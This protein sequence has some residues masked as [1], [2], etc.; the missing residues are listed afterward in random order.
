MTG[1]VASLARH[2]VKGFTPEKLE[3]ASLKAGEHFPGDRLYAV[4]D[5]L[6]GFDSDA[7]AHISKMAFTVLAKL[8]DV[9]AMRTKWNDDDGTLTASHPDLGEITI[10]LDDVGGQA[11]FTTW[12]STVLNGQTQGELKVLTAPDAFRFMDSRTGFVSIINLESVRDFEA[13]IGRKVDPARFRGNVMVENWPAWSEFEMVD[14]E[15]VIGGTRLRGLKPI[16][17]CTATHVDPQTAERD[18]DVV[19]LLREHYE[20]FDFG[21]YVEVVD[22]GEIKIGDAAQPAE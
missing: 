5:G 13:K 8:P 21:L 10:D 6:S 7:P 18:M 14:R 9:A 19:S 3:T 12:L 17:R 2:P 15:I 1:C 22:G 4:E 20:H 16:Q 11:V